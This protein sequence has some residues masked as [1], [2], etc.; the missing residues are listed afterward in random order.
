MRS[1]SG[2]GRGLAPTNH[3]RVLFTGYERDPADERIVT[4]LGG[5]VVERPSECTVLVTTGV[6]RTI[7]FMACFARGT[8]IVTPV[9]LA[10]SKQAKCFLDPWEFLVRDKAAEAKFWLPSGREPA[11]G[12]SPLAPA[13]DWLVRARDASGETSSGPAQRGDRVCGRCVPA[14]AAA[15]CRRPADRHLLSGG[16]PPLVAGASPPAASGVSRAAAQWRA[17]PTDRPPPTR[18][19]RV[20][21]VSVG[22]RGEGLCAD[23]HELESHRD[24]FLLVLCIGC[25]M[26]VPYAIMLRVLNYERTRSA[27]CARSL[28]IIEIDVL[29]YTIFRISAT[30]RAVLHHC[31][32]LRR[33]TTGWGLRHCAGYVAAPMEQVMPDQD[34]SLSL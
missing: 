24:N 8:P 4:S 5:A 18:A 27:R 32:M 16:R 11:Q 30:L 28:V 14:A 2:S 17:A 29:K 22:L 34:S 9:W 26:L 20:A 23:V 1:V 3:P 31:A 10:K 6:K 33:R 15:Q 12:Q 25:K 13:A 7:K 19:Q 21:A